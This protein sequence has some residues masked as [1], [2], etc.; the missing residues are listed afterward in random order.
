[1]TT[2]TVV[3]LIT[4]LY[5]GGAEAM[6]TK[7]VTTSGH[8]HFR[9][10][11]VSMI[12]DGAFGAPLR[13]AGVTVYRLEMPRGRPRLRALPQLLA[14]LRRERPVLLQTWMYHADLLGLL[15]APFFGRLP[16]VWN[17]RASDMDM[18]KYSRLSAWTLRACARLSPFPRAVVVNSLAGKVFHVRSG[19]HP[20]E[21]ALIPNGFDMHAYGPDSAARAV[22][23]AELGFGD[24]DI[25]IGLIARLDPMKDHPTFL[26]AAALLAARLPHARFLLAGRGVTADDPGL[27]RLLAAGDLTAKV[28]LL[29][30]RRDIPQL[31][32]ALDIAS[33]VS[34][35]GEGFPNVIGEAM[36]CEI[37]CVVTA[38]GDA[39][40]I[41]ADTGRVV[42]M[43]DP[44][45]L[46]AAWQH[47]AEMSR[48]ERRAIGVR[49]RQRIAEQYGLNRI[50]ERY[51]T[52]YAR[53][54]RR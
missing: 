48:E 1:M 41:V 2:I 5:S 7:L 15:I 17:I 24:D 36:A 49:A 28:R 53:L 20:R 10:V 32:A 12:D 26:R 40:T 27:R 3:H 46:A 29:G 43:R 31:M 11:V 6:L 25:V 51:E 9:H 18:A 50:V 14:I 45:A 22:I 35:Y 23:R 39:A 44:K 52:L 4:D 19:Y 16:V 13:A 30:E 38:V 47:L 33:L 37:P 21:W 42:P 34:T 8:P 54:A